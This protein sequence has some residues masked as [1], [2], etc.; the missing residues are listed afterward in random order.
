MPAA[1]QKIQLPKVTHKSSSCC[2]SVVNLSMIE[3]M[4]TLLIRDFSALW[5]VLSV[6]GSLCI[7]RVHFLYVLIKIEVV[8]GLDRCVRRVLYQTVF[9][10][11]YTKKVPLLVPM[12]YWLVG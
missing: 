2:R 10:G 3:I 12:G 8:M 6:C 11:L 1:K 4:R 9:Q 5:I 7:R